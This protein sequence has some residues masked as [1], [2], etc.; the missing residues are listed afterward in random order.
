[1]SRVVCILPKA[2]LGNQLFPLLNALV[3]GKL[4]DLPVTIIGYHHLKIGPY[5]RK[6]KIKRRYRGYFRFQKSVLGE[7]YD[8]FLSNG[9]LRII[10]AFMSPICCVMKKRRS[11]IK[12]LFSKNYPLIMIISFI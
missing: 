5:L 3:F 2:G 11:G 7:A 9:R 4:N 12:F 10:I 1:M 8:S 6:E